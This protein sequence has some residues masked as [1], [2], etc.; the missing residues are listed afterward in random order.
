MHIVNRTTFLTLPPGTLYA[1]VSPDPESCVMG[2]LLIKGD[3]MSNDWVVQELVGWFTDCDDSGDFIEAWDHLR[4]GGEREVELNCGA[5][6]GLFDDD[7]LFAVFS[8]TDHINLLKRLITAL[9]D[10]LA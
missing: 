4:A 1:K 6:D 7:Q 10:T 9:G 3:S 5:R 2:E 8:R